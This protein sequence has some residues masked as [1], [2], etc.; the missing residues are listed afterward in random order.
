[1]VNFTKFYT[2]SEFNI[3]QNI[4]KNITINNI[5]NDQDIPTHNILSNIDFIIYID[6]IR[7]KEEKLPLVIKKG[8]NI[9][10][11]YFSWYMTKLPIKDI[12]N[13]Y[14][15]KNQQCYEDFMNIF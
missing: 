5:L 3:Y 1:M 6:M 7:L 14:L 11:M 8:T 2:S 4:Y 13:I 9:T 15:I 10:T 12:K